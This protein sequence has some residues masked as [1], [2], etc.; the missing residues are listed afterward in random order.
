MFKVVL[1]AL[2]A[3]EYEFGQALSRIKLDDMRHADKLSGVGSGART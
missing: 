1:P 2:S 3:A